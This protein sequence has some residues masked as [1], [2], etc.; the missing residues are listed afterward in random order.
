[1]GIADGSSQLTSQCIKLWLHAL[2]RMRVQMDLS[3]LASDQNLEGGDFLF[4]FGQIRMFE[5]RPAQTPGWPYG[6]TSGALYNASSSPS[7][8]NKPPISSWTISN[9]FVTAGIFFCQTLMSRG[10]SG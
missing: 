2:V 1:M 10:R 4:V 5:L 6:R 9:S 8:R 7:P 3:S